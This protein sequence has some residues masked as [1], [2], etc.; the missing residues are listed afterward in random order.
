MLNIENGILKIFIFLFLGYRKT[1]LDDLDITVM[2]KIFRHFIIKEHDWEKKPKETSITP[3]DDIERI[4]THRNNIAH[5]DNNEM[6][7]KKFNNSAFE[8]IGVTKYQMP[9]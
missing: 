5:S 8:L 1:S 9:L 3:A 2:Y 7:T 6:T 4:R